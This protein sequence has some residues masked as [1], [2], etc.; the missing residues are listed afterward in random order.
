MA[1]NIQTGITPLYILQYPF[2]ELETCVQWAQKNKIAIFNQAVIHYNFKIQPDKITCMRK[3]VLNNILNGKPILE[4][5][6]P[7]G[8]PL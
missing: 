7:K 6:D 2:N 5:I 3:D 1:A 4:G 8:I